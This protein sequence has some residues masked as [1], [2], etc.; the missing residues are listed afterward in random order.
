M[1]NNVILE[2]VANKAEGK[3]IESLVEM[4]KNLPKEDMIKGVGILGV[5]VVAGMA[6]KTILQMSKSMVSP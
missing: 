2:E 6:M 4:C 3:V 1:T 5:V